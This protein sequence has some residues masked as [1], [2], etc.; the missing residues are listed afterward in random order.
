MGGHWRGLQNSQI[1]FDFL[2]NL[3]NLSAAQNRLKLGLQLP[4][5]R[6][7]LK[8]SVVGTY[9]DSVHF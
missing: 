8:R 7:A 5:A 1:F 2:N 4:T 3:I 6:I 9:L